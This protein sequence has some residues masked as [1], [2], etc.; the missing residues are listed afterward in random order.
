MLPLITPCALEGSN[1][2]LP[3][4]PNLN[5]FARYSVMQST[6]CFVSTWLLLLF[7]S[8]GLVLM[9]KH[10]RFVS[11]H[12]LHVKRLWTWAGGRLLLDLHVARQ[13][14]CVPVAAAMPTREQDQNQG[15][16]LLA[17]EDGLS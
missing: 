6:H 4:N 17:V 16:Q 3:A 5:A 2:R 9:A 7:L 13:F 8:F 10:L 1:T 14:C 11:R 15:L 12:P